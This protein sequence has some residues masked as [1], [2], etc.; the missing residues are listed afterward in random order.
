M[1]ISVSQPCEISKRGDGEMSDVFLLWRE[2]RHERKKGMSIIN[3]NIKISNPH[4]NV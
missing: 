2:D 1:Q 3:S 4:E